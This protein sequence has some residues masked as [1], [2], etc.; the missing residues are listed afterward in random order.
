MIT[1]PPNQRESRIIYLED[2][3]LKHLAPKRGTRKARPYYQGNSVT[4]K[5]EKPRA[6][7]IEWSNITRGIG[8][9]GKALEGRV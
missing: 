2:I 7:Y 9:G 5:K 1:L 3:E 6:Y 4:R 8:T